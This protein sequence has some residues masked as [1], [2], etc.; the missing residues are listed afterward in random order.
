MKMGN[1]YKFF[2]ISLSLLIGLKAHTQEPDF[3]EIDDDDL[4]VG[5]DIFSDFNEDIE[6]NQVTEDERF[7]RF[8]RFFSF[9]V[10]LGM[11]S[12]NG[13][14]GNAYDNDHPSYGLGLNYFPNFQSSF[15]M[16]FELSKH[17]MLIDFPVEGFDD[18][19]GN[20]GPGFVDVSMLRVYFSYRYYIDTANL[21]TAITFSN[22]YFT[23]RMEYWYTTNKYVD[24]S[25]EPNHSGGGLGFGVGGGF[26]F[27]IKL[28]ESYINTQFLFHKVNFIDKHVQKYKSTTPGGRGYDDLTG[29]VFS[30]FAGYVISW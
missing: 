15:G 4:S 29:N 2:L 18:R 5:Q 27:P 24:Q 1:F 12:F 26:E 20:Q 8:G 23:G 25:T 19:G 7:Y 17:H 16:G 9:Q 6:N 3:G 21:G 28:R 30:F 10:A 22:P 14:R 11:T 13:N